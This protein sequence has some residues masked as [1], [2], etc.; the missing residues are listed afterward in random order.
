MP[1]L[2]TAADLVRTI[3]DDTYRLQDVYRLA[4]QKRLGSHNGRRIP[5]FRSFRSLQALS[6]SG[7]CL[8]DFAVEVERSL[9]QQPGTLADYRLR[10]NHRH[11]AMAPPGPHRGAR[12]ADSHLKDACHLGARPT[13]SC[14]AALGQPFERRPRIVR[15]ST[16]VYTTSS[17]T[18]ASCSCAG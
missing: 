13:R 4:E 11:R 1:E 14:V 17:S 6:G 3:G 9:D 12:R 2:R 18:P 16:E 15:R 8:S 7:S 5:R 10:E